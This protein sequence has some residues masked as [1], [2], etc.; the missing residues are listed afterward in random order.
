MKHIIEAYSRIDEQAH[1]TGIALIP[2][3]SRNDNLYT[4]DELKRFDNK[5][6]P[7]NWEHDP[8]KKIG[9]VTF[10][11]NQEL[12][13]VF[14]DGMITDEGSANLARNKILFTS[15]EA[16][17]QGTKEIC[18]GPTD[19]FNMPFGLNPIGLAL[20]ETPGIPETSLKVIESFIKENC[21]QDCI[22]DK[23]DAGKDIDDKAIAICHSECDDNKEMAHCPE[24][25]IHKDGHCVDAE[26]L[27]KELN[28][29]NR[30]M[31]TIEERLE[32]KTCERCGKQKKLV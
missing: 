9:K 2:R 11:Y 6:V 26:I 20:T 27:R 29:L 16:D 17:P 1:I 21:V 22:K 4:K 7:L 3:I 28:L 30:R 12:E 23:K 18:N 25:Q 13:T 32:P 5:T 15:I 31:E 19:C 10:H 8:S 14:Y 24:G